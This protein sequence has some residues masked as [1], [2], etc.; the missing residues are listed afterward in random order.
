MAKATAIC[1]CH[2]CGAEFIR[3][4]IKRNS[5]EAEEWSRWA[6]VNFDL[7]AE[8]YHIDLIERFEQIKR[9][10]GIPEIT[11]VTPKQ[12]EYAERLRRDYALENTDAL[13]KLDLRLSRT[14]QAELSAAAAK[15]NISETDCL[16]AAVKRIGLYEA[17]VAMAESNAAIIIDTLRGATKNEMK[18]N[19]RWYP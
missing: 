13:E 7:C 12:I 9:K 5:R 11:G 17:Y 14:T 4:A 15:M 19:I 1:T 16:K 3:T 10:Y 8:C 2:K 18:N 6:S